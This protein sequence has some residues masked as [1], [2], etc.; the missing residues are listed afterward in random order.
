MTNNDLEPKTWTTAPCGGSIFARVSAAAIADPRLSAS[1][2]RT[3]AAL[4]LFANKE[5]ETFVSL[6]RI[7][8]IRGLSR[9]A[10]RAHL[11]EAARCGHHRAERRRRPNGADTSNLYRIVFAPAPE[12]SP[13]AR[14]TARVEGKERRR[15]DT[16]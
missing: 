3:L 2:L 11:R 1:V 8:E 15:R 14:V 16:L 5:G 4:A 9:T 10:V 7:A 6:A 12:I 13:V